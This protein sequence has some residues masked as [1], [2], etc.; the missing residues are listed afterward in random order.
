ML[1]RTFIVAIAAIA[2]ACDGESHITFYPDGY[3][4]QLGWKSGVYEYYRCYLTPEPLNNQI[5]N[6]KFENSEWLN[7]H[8]ALIVFSN[9]NCSGDYKQWQL[10]VG[11]YKSWD[12]GFVGWYMNDRI[13]SWKISGPNLDDEEGHVDGGET[14][15]IPNYDYSGS[16]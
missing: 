1:P 9:R 3:L 11:T 13:Q 4:D 5:S 2:Y 8:F 12:A 7:W 14:T 16:E 10:D 15:A 6:I